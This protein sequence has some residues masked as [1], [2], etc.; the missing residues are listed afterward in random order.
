MGYEP[1]ANKNPLRVL[2][3]GKDSASEMGLIM[4]RAGLGKT[5]LLVQIA[6]ACK[7]I[8]GECR[9]AGL[10][11]QTGTSGEVGHHGDEV[12][13]LDA[14]ANDA[15]A[16]C[17]GHTGLAAAIVSEE[18]EEPYLPPGEAAGPAAPRPPAR[19]PDAAS[20]R[21]PPTP[22]GARNRLSGRA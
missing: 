7:V 16:H 4:A 13:R 10:G 1:L 18:M 8:G 21:R 6:S 2:K 12:Q 5:A 20:L 14:F 3:I 22:P 17:F 19:R 15:F 9:R 11:A